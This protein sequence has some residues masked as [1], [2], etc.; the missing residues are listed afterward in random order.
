M[1][2]KERVFEKLIEGSIG[3][4]LLSV[5]SFFLWQKIEN[6]DKYIRVELKQIKAG[7]YD[8]L[9]SRFELVNKQAIEFNNT[10]I[11]N[12]ELLNEV[13]FKM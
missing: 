10:L 3:V 5:I 9:D 4:L 8:C 13:K 12:N 11:E 6:N 1:N 7:Y 2:F